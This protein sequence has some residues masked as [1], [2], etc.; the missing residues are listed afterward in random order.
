M[1]DK[2]WLRSLVADFGMTFALDLVPE[3]QAWSAHFGMEP[4]RVESV[5]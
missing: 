1:A 2:K 5:T 3:S 4:I